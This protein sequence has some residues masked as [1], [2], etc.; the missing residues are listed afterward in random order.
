[1]KH[2]TVILVML[3]LVSFSSC[4]YFKGKKFFGKKADT[5][6]VWQARQ[7]SIHVT[8][9]IRMIQE[10][11]Q[12]IEQARIDSIEARRAWEINNKYNIIV[13]SFLTPEYA[14]GLAETYKTQGYNTNIIKMEG[15][16][17]DLVSI[18]AKADLKDA[19]VR[20]NECRNSLQPEA[21]VYI[22]K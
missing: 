13:G 2:F 21:W 19:I 7:D 14:K 6:A 12:A 22:R 11:L 9:S 15:G 8:D 4:K 1:M 10:R 20:L 16:R 3:L 18:D 17:F 5:M